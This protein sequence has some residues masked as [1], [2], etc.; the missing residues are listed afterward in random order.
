MNKY[1]EAI[2]DTINRFE[3]GP[4]CTHL[5]RT[6]Y[7]HIKDYSRNTALFLDLRR[8]IKDEEVLASYTDRVVSLA[9]LLYILPEED[10]QELVIDY[11]SSL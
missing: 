7:P 6:I 4:A 10:M 1:S 5:A 2:A 3:M 9:A 11:Y 8:A